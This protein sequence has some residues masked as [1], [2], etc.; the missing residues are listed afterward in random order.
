MDEE[1]RGGERRGGRLGLSL[2]FVRE[3]WR[4]DMKILSEAKR[5]EG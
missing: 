2:I 3:D 5:K 4:L 1:G